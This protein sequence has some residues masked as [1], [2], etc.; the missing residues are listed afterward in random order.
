VSF[1]LTKEQAVAGAVMMGDD[2]QKKHE[3]IQ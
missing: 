3:E 2:S 1:S